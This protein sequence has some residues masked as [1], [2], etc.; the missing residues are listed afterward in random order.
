MHLT[1]RPG[2]RTR[3]TIVAVA[4]LAVLQVIVVGGQLLSPAR[5]AAIQPVAIAVHDRSCGT[6]GLDLCETLVVPADHRHPHGAATEEV[7]FG[8]HT[9]TR[10][11]EGTLVIAVGGPGFAGLDA[12]PFYLESLP[13]TLVNR[14]DLVFFDARG[15]GRSGR[16]TCRSAEA[17]EP[18]WAQRAESLEADALEDASVRWSSACLDEAGITADEVDRYS[19]RQVVDDLEAYRRHRGIERLTIYGESYGTLVAQL[20]AAR[21]PAHTSRIIIDGPVD[22]TLDGFAFAVESSHGFGAALEQTMR[23]CADDPICAADF[24][25]AP[26]RAWADLADRFE[27]DILEIEVVDADGIRRPRAVG[28]QELDQLAVATLY[29]TTERMLLQRALAAASH[30]DFGPLA[31]LLDAYAISAPA[32]YGATSAAAFLAIR[33]ADYGRAPTA[34]VDEIARAISAADASGE[35]LSRDLWDELPCFAG[36]EPPGAD[37]RPLIA[38]DEPP[39]EVS[40][41]VLTA[42]ADPVTPV[43]MARRIAARLPNAHLVETEGGPHVTFPSFGDCPD[44]IVVEFI[45]DGDLPA[46]DRTICDG[47]VADPYVPLLRAS[48][49]AYDDVGE[50]LRAV[51]EDLYVAP[52]YLLWSGDGVRVPC[53]NGGTMTLRSGAE[54]D[55]FGFSRCQLFPDWPID[56]SARFSLDGTTTMQLTAPDTELEYHSDVNWTVTVSGTYD[57]IPIQIGE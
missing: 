57:G 49:D 1:P 38:P 21:Y 46:D 7:A 52:A 50:A 23:A 55:V 5:G 40:T 2:R 18:D 35:L 15:V 6:S 53:R 28:V 48:V 9:A 13:P 24:D 42:T 8:V 37:P 33:C 27:R 14:L 32:T 39:S 34:P 51:E 41:L 43:E 19:T 56:G 16:L 3:V 26:E 22:A 4:F 12:A 11:A 25:G 17:A 30:R 44:D 20:Y 10:T 31:E 47:F 29:S 45:L 36:F 54:A